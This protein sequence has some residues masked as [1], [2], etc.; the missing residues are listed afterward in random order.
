[1]TT[2]RT[3]ETIAAFIAARASE[4]RE[5]PICNDGDC[6]WCARGITYE[7]PTYTDE[8]IAYYSKADECRMNVLGTYWQICGAPADGPCHCDV[9]VVSTQC[10]GFGCVDCRG[11]PECFTGHDIQDCPAIRALLFS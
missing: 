1:M 11:C 3:P 10:T 8:E 7:P 2:E 6:P 5:C 9:M 4:P